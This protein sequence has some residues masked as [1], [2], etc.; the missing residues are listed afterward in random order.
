MKKKRCIICT[1]AGAENGESCSAVC[2]E[3]LKWKQKGLDRHGKRSK[4]PGTYRVTVSDWM[5]ILRAFNHRCAYCGKAGEMTIDHV[6][7][8]SR[9]GRHC[10]GNLVPACRSCNFSKGSMTIVEWRNYSYKKVEAGP[11]RPW[12]VDDKMGIRPVRKKYKP[13]QTPIFSQLM[14]EMYNEITIER[15][16]LTVDHFGVLH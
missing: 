12:T 9:G 7:P 8:I 6:L 11:I 5:K 14:E 10:V 4:L 3:A 15:L 16:N 1:K 2:A 13:K